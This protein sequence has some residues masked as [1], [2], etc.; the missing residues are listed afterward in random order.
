[1]KLI[2]YFFLITTT[3]Y[4]LQ[5]CTPSQGKK[6]TDTTQISKEITEPILVLTGFGVEAESITLPELQKKFCAGEVY[7]LENSAERVKKVFSCNTASLKKLKNIREFAPLAKNSLLLVL[8][9]ESTPQFKALA[10]DS[11]YF[12]QNAEKYPLYAWSEAKEKFDF[13]QKITRFTLTGTTAVTRYMGRATDQYGTDW[14]LANILERVKGS[15]FLHISN[16]VSA[17]EK[18][19]YVPGMRFCMKTKHLEIFTKLGVN[20][21]ELTGNHNLDYGKE[22]YIKT[23]EWYKANGMQIFGG[24]LSV[25]DAY[26]PL[27]LTLKDGKK[28]AMVGFNESC[29]V[30]ECAGRRGNSVG[31]AAYDSLKVMQILQDLRKNPDISYIIASVQFDETDSYAPTKSQA[32]ITKYLLDWGADFVYGSQAHQVQQVE[33]YKGKPIFHG[34]GNFLFDQIHRIGVRQGFFLHTYFYQGKMVQAV[35]IFTFTAT[36]RRPALANNEQIREIKKVIFLD[37]HLYQ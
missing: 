4:L 31:A 33:F 30:N 6:T 5:S 17:T 37:K 1:M 7:V 23:Y 2:S 16:E 20:I 3:W 14:L 18:C 27:I 10:I 24:G 8:L 12:F 15:D 26:K 9:S 28:I 13:K 25:E 36:E 22:G 21:V 11:L 34:F 32:K 19:E 35:P 29:P